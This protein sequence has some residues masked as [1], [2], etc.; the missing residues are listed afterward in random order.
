MFL[1]LKA[2]AKEGSSFCEQKEAKKLCLVWAVGVGGDNA[3]GPA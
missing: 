2:K 3:H 1:R